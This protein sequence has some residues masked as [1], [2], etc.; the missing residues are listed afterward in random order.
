M[1][2]VRAVEAG[3]VQH[4]AHELVHAAGLLLDRGEV[5]RVFL[6]RDILRDG[7]G[8]AADQRERGLEVV[9]RR[10]D[11]LLPLVLEVALAVPARMQV[12]RHVAERAG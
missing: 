7:F 12:A 4:F 5:A 2:L 3:V 8:V 1:Q 11:E 10:G 6:G 9:A